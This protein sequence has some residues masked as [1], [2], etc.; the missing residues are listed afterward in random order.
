[1]I[2]FF[3]LYC[4]DVCF[5]ISYV[6]CDF[7]SL[8][9]FPSCQTGWFHQPWKPKTQKIH[10]PTYKAS[11]SKAYLFCHGNPCHFQ[12]EHEWWCLYL[13]KTRMQAVSPGWAARLQRIISQSRMIMIRKEAILTKALRALYKQT[14]TLG[15]SDK[16]RVGFANLTLGAIL[17]ICDF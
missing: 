17:R 8:L 5:K 11:A 12:L 3:R 15:V 4:L 16:E 7:S 10:T 2:L 9:L 13:Q 1:M 14:H 6:A